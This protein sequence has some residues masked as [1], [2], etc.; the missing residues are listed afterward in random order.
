MRGRGHRA[1]AKDHREGIDS[2][3]YILPALCGFDCRSAKRALGMA[4]ALEEDVEERDSRKEPEQ[5]VNLETDSRAGSARSTIRTRRPARSCSAGSGLHQPVTERWARRI[6]RASMPKTVRRW[7]TTS[8]CGGTPPRGCG[9]RW[10]GGRFS[11][12]WCRSA[13]AFVIIRCERAANR[14]APS[15][16][17]ER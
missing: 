4:A 5:V 14:K 10:C 15:S 3:F 9:M 12:H 8:R 11:G 7:R 1:D 6:T 2:V 16:P 17:G 13:R